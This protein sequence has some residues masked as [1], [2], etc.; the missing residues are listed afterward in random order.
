MQM[1]G[2]KKEVEETQDDQEME[3]EQMEQERQD[4]ISS[5]VHEENEKEETP[6]EPKEKQEQKARGRRVISAEEWEQRNKNFEAAIERH[7]NMMTVDSVIRKH[8]QAV[9][10][11]RDR[12]LGDVDIAEIFASEY[13]LDMDAKDIAKAM[14]PKRKRTRKTKDTE[15]E[16][17]EN[18]I[19]VSETAETTEEAM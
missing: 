8:R 16:T 1:W 7:I 5:S 11:L 14:K 4:D 17:Q 12:G 2:T 19:T 9:K 15:T 10:M 13:G 3:Q 18:I 6:K